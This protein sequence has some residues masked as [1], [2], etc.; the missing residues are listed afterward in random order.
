MLCIVC[1]AVLLSCQ[2]ENAHT[3][4]FQVSAVGVFEPAAVAVEDE[5]KNVFIYRK[6]IVSEVHTGIPDKYL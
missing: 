6:F 2:H 3:N 1:Q 4:Y 5:Y